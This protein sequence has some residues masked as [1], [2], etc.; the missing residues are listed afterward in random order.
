MKEQTENNYIIIYAFLMCEYFLQPDN[1]R[2][3]IF[4]TIPTNNV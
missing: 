1:F 2:T 3:N 4:P